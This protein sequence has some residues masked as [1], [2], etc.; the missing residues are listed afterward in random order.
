MLRTAPAACLE[1]TETPLPAEEVDTPLDEWTKIS[2]EPTLAQPSPSHAEEQEGEEPEEVVHSS[3]S[4][5]T[6]DSEAESGIDEIV[7]EHAPGGLNQQ[8]VSRENPGDEKSEYYQHRV[9]KVVHTLSLFGSSF[10]CGRQLGKEYRQCSLLL[11]VDSMRCQQCVRRSNGR[12][13]PDLDC[14][15]DAVVKRARRA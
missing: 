5:T 7:E 11:V 1:P 10:L 13:L 4:S 14:D 8:E 9:S 15:L 3:S 2:T 12:S 6:S